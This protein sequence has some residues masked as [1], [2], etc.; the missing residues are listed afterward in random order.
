MVAEALAYP[1][2]SPS[3]L[4]SIAEIR[5]PRQPTEPDAIPLR[6]VEQYEVGLE[7]SDRAADVEVFAQLLNER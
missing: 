6:L 4:W 1:L 2:L 7:P 5:V 3:L